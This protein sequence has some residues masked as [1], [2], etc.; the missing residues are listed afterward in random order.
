METFQTHS[1]LFWE[2][3]FDFS[4]ADA[5]ISRRDMIQEACPLTKPTQMFKKLFSLTF[6]AIFFFSQKFPYDSSMVSPDERH[7]S[8]LF[9]MICNWVWENS[10]KMPLS[11]KSVLCRRTGGRCFSKL[12]IKDIA[13]PMAN[14]NENLI[15]VQQGL[16]RRNDF[17]LMKETWK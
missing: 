8:L 1:I 4:T 6:M 2:C 10:I 13:I 11:H 17:L 12:K 3:N 9:Q 7:I 5:W 15:L 14:E 16:G